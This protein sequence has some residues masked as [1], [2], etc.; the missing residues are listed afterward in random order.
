[1]ENNGPS[2]WGKS[3]KQ[4]LFSIS[5]FIDLYGVIEPIQTLFLSSDTWPRR[6]CSF[7]AHHY[8]NKGIHETQRLFQQIDGCVASHRSGS[9]DIYQQRLLFLQALLHHSAL[10]SQRRTNPNYVYIHHLKT[11]GEVNL[12]GFLEEHQL[13]DHEIAAGLLPFLKHQQFLIARRVYWYLE[14]QPLPV[15]IRKLIYVFG[16]NHRD[17]L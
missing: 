11:S 3:N 15:T 17:S 14:G 16:E 2:E 5:Y 7:L 13:C 4:S 12:L 8:F 9:T 10:P 6:Y 1:M